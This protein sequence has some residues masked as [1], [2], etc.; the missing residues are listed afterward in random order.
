[1]A[2]RIRSVS[3]SISQVDKVREY[4]ANQEAHH[5]KRSFGDEFIALLVANEIEFDEKYL[6][7]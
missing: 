7:I 2:A 6:D 5:S 1:M 4:I 3:V